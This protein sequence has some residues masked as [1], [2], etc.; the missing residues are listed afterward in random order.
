MTQ[1]DKRTLTISR[2][3][4]GFLNRLPRVALDRLREC[5]DDTVRLV[6]EPQ[7][8]NQ[9]LAISGYGAVSEAE[10]DSAMRL[11]S[12]EYDKA[13]SHSIDILTTWDEQYPQR[14]LE[15]PDY[16][17][18]LFRYG[19]C[20]LNEGSFLAI[21]GTRRCTVYGDTFTRRTVKELT[22]MVPRLTIVSGLAFGIDAAAHSSALESGAPTVG[23]LAHGFGTIY[24]AQH[25]DLARGIREHGGCLLTE[26]IWGERPF[27][28]RFLERNR[29][30][31]GLS[32]AVLVTESAVKGGAMST[33]NIAFSINRTLM[34]LPGRISDESSGGCNLLIA[35]Q[36]AQLVT[37]PADVAHHMGLDLAPTHQLPVLPLLFPQPDGEEKKIYE[38]ISMSREPIQLDDLCARLH[39]PVARLSA[40]LGEMEFDGLV[41][42]LPGNRYVTY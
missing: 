36:K 32:D 38:I 29:I 4:L 33:A 37:S 13:T 9:A 12:A 14:L 20:D 10:I 18:V 30:V 21:V 2:M 41:T 11:A 17:R 7:A 39:M 42:R 16:P 5:D 35:Q 27:R 26:Y 23:V 22:P 31:A 8:L 6:S 28:Q 24:P 25:R 15:T 1:S 3:A 34:A 19:D 40:L